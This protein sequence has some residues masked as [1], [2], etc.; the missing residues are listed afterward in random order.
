MIELVTYTTEN[1]SGLEVSSPVRFQGR[2]GGPCQRGP[3]G[4]ARR[5]PSKS[6]S[7]CSSTAST[8]LASNVERIRRIADFRRHGPQASRP[9]GEKPR[10]GRGVLAARCAEEPPAADRARVHTGPAVRSVDAL[11]RWR[12]CRIACLQSWS[13]R[14]RRCGA[15]REIVSQGSRQPRPKRSILHQRRAH[16]S[17][18]RAPG[19]ERRFAEVLLDHDQRADRADHSR[20]RRGDRT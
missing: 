16:H 13:A 11:D 9:G 4:P 20:A 12:R 6:T 15:L 17:G 1:V 19:V 2:V 3:R 7:R 10:D 14:R 8:P 5:S 18:E